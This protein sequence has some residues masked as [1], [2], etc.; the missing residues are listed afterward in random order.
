MV[1]KPRLLLGM[2]GSGPEGVP[3]DARQRGEDTPT[4]PAPQA[5]GMVV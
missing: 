2:A 1:A 3:A 5:A 4:V